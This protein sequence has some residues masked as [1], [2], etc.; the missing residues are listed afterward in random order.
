[1][2]RNDSASSAGAVYVFTRAAGSW[3]Q[4]AFVKASN[5]SVSD[6]FGVALALSADGDTLAVGAIGESGSV[7][8]VSGNREDN[9]AG[10]AGAVYVY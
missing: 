5:T 6:Q 2:S 7:A 3:S 1:M 8:K 10:D 9:G 4:Q